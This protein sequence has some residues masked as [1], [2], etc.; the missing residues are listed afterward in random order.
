MLLFVYMFV[1]RNRFC[2]GTEKCNVVKIKRQPQVSVFG[3]LLLFETRSLTALELANVV[4]L[5]RQILLL[6]CRP[7]G[8]GALQHT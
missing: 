8:P 3:L 6:G 7:W 4:S 1:G 5:Q 2:I